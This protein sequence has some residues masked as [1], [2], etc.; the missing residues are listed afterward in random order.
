MNVQLQRGQII[1]HGQ[2]AN[3]LYL[4]V[5]SQLSNGLSYNDRCR[6]VKV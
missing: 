5:I 2:Y 3:S 6:L 1:L 4:M